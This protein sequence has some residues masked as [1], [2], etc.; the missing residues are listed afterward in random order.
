MRAEGVEKTSK[1]SKSRTRARRAGVG[2]FG[3]GGT[4]A[5]LQVAA[6]RPRLV[7]A[8]HHPDEL[9]GEEHRAGVTHSR[10]CR[11]FDDTFV[12]DVVG[13]GVGARSARVGGSSRRTLGFAARHD[14]AQERVGERIRHGVHRALAL[15]GTPLG[16]LY[17]G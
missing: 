14:S 13:V 1:E 15:L 16:T 7:L 10:G 8:G 5:V 17:G 11:E 2:G 12:V 3:G 9:R 6:G 4:G